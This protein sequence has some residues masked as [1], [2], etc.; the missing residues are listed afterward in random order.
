MQK[1]VAEI[2]RELSQT[3]LLVT[4]DIEEALLLADR[5][6]VIDVYKRQSSD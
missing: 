4:H 2:R 6:Y 3:I 1:L 5:I